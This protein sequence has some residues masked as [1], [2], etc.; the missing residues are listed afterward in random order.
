MPLPHA[1]VLVTPLCVALLLL[2]SSLHADAELLPFTVKLDVVRQELHPDWCWFHPRAAAIPGAGKGGRPAIILTLQKHL[3]VSDYYSG[4]YFMR[5]DDCGATWTAPVLPPELDWRKDG[6]E[7]IAVCDVTPGWH[8][9]TGKLLAIGPKLRYGPAGDQLVDRPRSHEVSCAVYDP[10]TNH[11]SRWQEMTMPESEGK[12][13]LTTPGCVQ[14]LV[15]SDGTLLLPLYFKGPAGDDYSVT[16]VNC[17]FDGRTLRY[18][19][20]GDEMALSGGRGLCEPSLVRYRGRYYMTVRN[21]ARGYVTTSE[22]GL[23]WAPIQPWSFDDGSELGSYNTQAHWLTHSDGLF[24]AYTRRGANND[25]IV[26]NRAPLFIAQVDPNRLCVFRATERVLMPERGVMLGNFGANPVDE[27]ESWV[28][29][30]EFAFGDK[31][32]PRGADGSVFAARVQ[33]SRPNRLVRPTRIICLGDS[34]TQGVRPGVTPEQP[35]AWLLERELQRR[36]H[37]AEV[38]NLGVGGQRTDEA[39]ERLQRD[40][41]ARQPGIVAIMYG[42]NDSYVDAGAKQPRLSAQQY[43]RNLTDLVLRL[44]ESGIQPVLMTEPCWGK[45]VNG[46][47]EDPNVRLGGYMDVCRE[48]ARDVRVPLVDHFAFWTNRA[49]TMDI[50]EW[51]TDQCHP[52]AAGH[53]VLMQTMLPVVEGLL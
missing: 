38:L 20:H 6:N 12:F 24:L 46:L 32:A 9:A 45:A 18:L 49:Q 27:N 13:W 37:A 19:R 40:V 47:G 44:R 26:R 28:T 29:D 25:H 34:I 2:M 8:A 16:V 14:W 7:T 53:E 43:R 23:H 31:P 22:D 52:N 4:L 48:V 50:G 51:T 33:W 35:F 15:N 41:I 36:G 39:L 30:A 42:T 5:S 1:L 10:A 11:W 17:A 3:V 21:D